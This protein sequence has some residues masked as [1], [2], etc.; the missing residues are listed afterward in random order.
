MSGYCGD[1]RPDSS[2]DEDAWR[3]EH[4]NGVN[5]GVE[6][7]VDELAEPADRFFGGP[8]CADCTAKW[9]AE[10]RAEAQ[11]DMLRAS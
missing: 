10:D 5:C 1:G 9:E 2:H 7:T 8:Y 11:A 6:L 3:R 4:C